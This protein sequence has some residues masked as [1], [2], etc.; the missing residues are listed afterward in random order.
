MVMM[1]QQRHPLNASLSREAKKEE[2]L[3][4]AAA[5]KSGMT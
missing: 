3:G 1:A 4:V 2:T 5:A